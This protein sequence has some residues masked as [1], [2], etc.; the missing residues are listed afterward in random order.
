[1]IQFLFAQKMKQFPV[2][3]NNVTYWQWQLFSESWCKKTTE[4]KFMKS[5]TKQVSAAVTMHT[6]LHEVPDS[7]L[8]TINIRT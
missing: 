8:E 4:E 7:N 2:I 3:L 1:L 6:S 5:A